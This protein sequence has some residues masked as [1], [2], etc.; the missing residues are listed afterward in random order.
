ML[1]LSHPLAGSDN[2]VIL[3]KDYDVLSE[4]PLHTREF[5]VDA[6]VNVGWGSKTSQFHG[7][8][9]KAAAQS[10][11]IPAVDRL[12]LD[13][14][15]DL[16]PRISWRGDSAF[17]AISLVEDVSDP[18]SSQAQQCRRVR[19]LSR[20]GELSSTS[21]PT[22]HL[23]H[24]LAWQPSGSIIASSHKVVDENQHRII[25]YERNGLRR[26]DFGLKDLNARVRDLQWNSSSTL[27]A[28]WL[29]TDH[30]ADCVQLWA[31]SNYEWTL[32]QELSAQAFSSASLS[33]VRWNPENE[34]EL[35]LTT[36]DTVVTFRLAWHVARSYRK[37]PFDDG[38]VAVIDGVTLASGE[39]RL[40]PEIGSF[41]EFCHTFQAVGSQAE[42]HVGITSN[43]RLFVGSQL[44]ASDA[45]SFLVT[46]DFLVF[47][48]FNHQVKFVPTTSLARGLSQTASAVHS[49]SVS[50]NEG[51]SA[52]TTQRAIERGAQIITIIPSST[53]V[54]LQMPRGNLETIC[55]RPLV[56]KVVANHL[57]NR[58]AGKIN[59]VCDAIRAE[60][61]RDL[62]RHLHCVLTAHVRKTP[63][64]YESALRLL[65]DINARDPKSADKAVKY[66]IFLSEA[67][68]LFDLALG[69]YDFSLVLMVA[70]HS[71]KDPRE[72]L[73]FLRELRKLEPHLQRFRIDD[74]L[75][76][77]ASALRH[78]AQAGDAYFEQVLSYA[79]EH[80]LHLAALQ[81]YRAD[82]ARHKTVLGAHAQSLLDN[83]R[84]EEAGLAYERAGNYPEAIGAFVKANLW[85]NAFRLCLTHGKRTA[86]QIKEL[87]VDVSNNLRAKR[88]FAE[89]GRV[90]LEYARDVDAACDI[91]LEGNE[92]D[93]AHRIASLYN[94]KELVETLIKPA[95]L[96]AK[97]R[98]TDEFTDVQ[99]QLE[100]QVSRLDELRVKR[101]QE[102]ARFFCRE[103]EVGQNDNIEMQ[104]DGAS[105]AGTAFTRYTVAASTLATSRNTSNRSSRTA[106]S[107]KRASLKR[108]AG[109]KGTV[110]EESYLLNSVKKTVETRLLELQNEAHNVITSLLSVHSSPHHAA[111]VELQQALSAL[112]SF[113]IETV[114]ELWVWREAEW[115]NEARELQDRQ[116][117]GD[118][119]GKADLPLAEAEKVTR[120]AVAQSQWRISML[121]TDG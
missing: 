112:S 35:N 10:A 64:D 27:L 43:G 114:D 6:P 60:L 73:P 103:D 96:E 120:P 82:P 44:I 89:A 77:F 4:V 76:R 53:S 39:A 69:L 36:V 75:Q 79:R 12:V 66:I 41:P 118:V 81:L 57:S 97:A 14:D 46:D 113:T 28:V 87:A 1:T 40:D 7:S 17:V 22:E 37:P 74:H 24:A 59:A 80:D 54:V 9:G 72:Y 38:A 45:S 99:E 55:P 94:R 47:T 86:T 109:K 92:F 34:L 20:V 61:E 51:E 21:E 30:A 48:T 19:I 31:R 62:S 13:V 3:T 102:P 11:P 115:A 98:L 104:A 8:V 42:H 16:R 117:R 26:Y 56:L 25:F 95:L 85:Q 15:D 70:Q 68:K 119:E 121:D 83:K 88:R 52:G 65:S 106:K 101:E 5:G 93:E 84:Y 29:E 18:S 23:G 50:D 90:V 71:Q 49:H 108:A 63:A 91:L 111:A 2:L 32:K 116:D 78:L 107:R 67:N 110:F 33:S 100:K 58:S 105:D